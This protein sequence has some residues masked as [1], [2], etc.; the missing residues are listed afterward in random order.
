MFH[1]DMED[2]V[3]GRTLLAQ[4]EVIVRSYY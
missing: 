3:A 2:V 1:A 4:H